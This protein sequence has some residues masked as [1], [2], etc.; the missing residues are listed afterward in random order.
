MGA[1][2]T[3]VFVRDIDLDAID[4]RDSTLGDH[5]LVHVD[6]DR[7]TTIQ[8]TLDEMLA[9]IGQVHEQ[10]LAIQA[11]RDEAARE[12]ADRVREEPRPSALAQ[13]PI[14]F[15]GDGQDWTAKHA[16][17]AFIRKQGWAVGPSDT[18]HHRGVMFSDE[19]AISKWK[20]LTRSERQECDA[21]LVGRGRDGD[22][23]LRAVEPS[24]G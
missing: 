9:V 4:T 7:V 23:V 24:D 18:T 20:Y 22:L 6:L 17:E 21:V 10:L 11:E 15:Y 12:A 3:T 1:T 16:A 2:S 5:D 8:G 14:T 13:L 19:Y